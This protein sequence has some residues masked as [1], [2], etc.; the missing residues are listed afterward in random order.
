[1]PKLRIFAKAPSY[2]LT[3]LAK[4]HE[5]SKPAKGRVF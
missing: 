1:M 4:K 3:A 2:K 5:R